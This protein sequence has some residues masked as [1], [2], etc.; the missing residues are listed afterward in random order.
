[1]DIGFAT[2]VFMYEVNVLLK[3]VF[4]TAEGGTGKRLSHLPLIKDI[5]CSLEDNCGIQKTQ[6]IVAAESRPE[7]TS[8]L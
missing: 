1:M 4:G 2:V 8:R 5:E 7:R 6:T 3:T